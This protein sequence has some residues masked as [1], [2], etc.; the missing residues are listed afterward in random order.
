MTDWTGPAEPL[1]RDLLPVSGESVGDPGAKGVVYVVDASCYFKEYLEPVD[2]ASPLDELIGWRRSLPQSERDFLDEHCA[3]PLRRVHRDGRTTGFLMT[4]A[5]DVFWADMLGERHTVELQHLIHTAAAKRLGLDVPDRSERLRLVRDLAALFALFD[6]HHMVYGDISEKNV[7]WTVRG[8][9]RVYLID[10]DNARPADSPHAGSVMARNEGWRDPL[11]GPDDRP[12]IDSDRFALAVFFYRV[13][14]GVTASVDQDQ[15]RILLPDDAPHLP[16]LEELLGAGLGLVR[17]RPSA[18]RWLAAVAAQRRP[19]PATVAAAPPEA[20]GSRRRVFAV[21]AAGVLVAA[22]MAVPLIVGQTHRDTTP[23]SASSDM[24]SPA[25][26]SPPS[27]SPSPSPVSLG[28]KEAMAQWAAGPVKM[29]VDH[30]NSW[31]YWPEKGDDEEPA[32]WAQ[33][34]IS[35]TNRGDAGLVLSDATGRLLLVTN[36]EPEVPSAL[37]TVVELPGLNAGQELYGV[38]FQDLLTFTYGGEKQDVA[39]KGEQVDPGATFTAD[40]PDGNGVS[41]ELTPPTAD[42]GDD[43]DV[44]PASLH[45]VGVAWVDETGEVQGFTPV[46]A[47]TG[48]NTTDSFLA[49]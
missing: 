12:D 35:L 48:P 10:C 5:P 37:V 2:D 3:W 42:P 1:D 6:T 31:V 16:E 30:Y 25:P 45:I 4:P 43:Q 13:F 26:P 22:A 7:L 47:W 38:P 23:T 49:K 20:D 40:S 28:R 27:P 9:P 36:A 44:T 18:A 41:Y 21:T 14:Y 8:T 29:R 15:G 46:S 32:S 34:R 33:L 24:I 17:P 11:L 39:W 19:P